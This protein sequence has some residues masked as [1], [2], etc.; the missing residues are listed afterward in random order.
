METWGGALSPLLSCVRIV[1]FLPSL[2]QKKKEAKN[3]KLVQERYASLS[4]CRANL[5]AGT[6]P[7]VSSQAFN[8]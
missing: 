4:V 3:S 7:Q 8:A 2:G 6:F 5:R 1:E